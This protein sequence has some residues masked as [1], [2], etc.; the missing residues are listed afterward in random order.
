MVL[1][2]LWCNVGFAEK[3]LLTKCFSNAKSLLQ[4]TWS[5]TN[6]WSITHEDI[7]AIYN[8]NDNSIVL[9]SINKRF[10]RKKNLSRILKKI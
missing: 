5:D 1:G 4:G 9:Y 10:C 2:L 6:I 8:K 7:Q 3:I